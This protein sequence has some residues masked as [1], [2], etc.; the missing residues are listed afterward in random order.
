MPIEALISWTN[1]GKNVF[2]K[3]VA[4]HIHSQF[5]IYEVTLYVRHNIICAKII[6]GGGGG[7]GR[8]TII[9]AIGE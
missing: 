1:F 7:W 4:R 2:F 9:L 5:N 3:N 8:Y 6:M